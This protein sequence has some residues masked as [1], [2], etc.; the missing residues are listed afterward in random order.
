[1]NIFKVGGKFLDQPLLVAKFNKSVPVLLTTA[2]IGYC[3]HNTQKV[4]E[5]DKKNVAIKTGI[6][7]G[8]TILSALIAPKITNK[9]FNIESKSI[10]EIKNFNKDLIN[11]FLTHH[12]QSNKTAEILNKAKT[13]VISF[14]DIKHLYANLNHTFEGK[15]FFDKLI[16]NPENITSKEIFSEIC[17]LS[18]L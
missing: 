2:G 14:N 13:K 9:L 7:M 18:L 16:P 3:L 17:R 8:I 5:E 12:K 4:A 6:T 15:K 10:N 1:M 11:N